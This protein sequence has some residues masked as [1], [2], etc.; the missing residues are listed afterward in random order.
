[1]ALSW[2]EKPPPKIPLVLTAHEDF[3]RE[4]A[5]DGP[6]DTFPVGTTITLVLYD[7]TDPDASETGSWPA[8][9]GATTAKWSMDHSIADQIPTPGGYRLMLSL[10]NTADTS[11]PTIE[12]CLAHGRL[13]RE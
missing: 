6:I 3:V 10:P 2:R 9:V 4:L 8:T 11:N 13:T 1:M 5:F 7:G 12:R